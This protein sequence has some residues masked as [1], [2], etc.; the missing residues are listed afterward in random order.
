MGH[1]RG[2]VDE[3]GSIEEARPDRTVGSAV[4]RQFSPLADTPPPAEN[5]PVDRQGISVLV[6]P[7]TTKPYVV[8]YT[9]ARVGSNAPGT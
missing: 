6:D 5:S 2:S 7:F 4:P 3:L 9:T 8:F 1:G